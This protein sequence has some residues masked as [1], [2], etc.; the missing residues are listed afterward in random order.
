MTKASS[1]RS[2]YCSIQ[3]M[4]LFPSVHAFSTVPARVNRVNYLDQLLHRIHTKLAERIYLFDL[5]SGFFF[6]KFFG[7]L[8][9]YDL[10]WRFL[11]ES[12]NVFKFLN[13]IGPLQNIFFRSRCQVGSSTTTFR[14]R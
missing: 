7:S 6:A 12:I 14:R 5:F 4:A 3:N 13:R 9:T 2:K 10:W 8:Y 1:S 11:C